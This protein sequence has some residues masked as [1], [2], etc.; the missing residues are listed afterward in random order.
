MKIKDVLQRDPAANPLINQGQARITDRQNERTM[1]ELY[2]E[3]STFV[4]EGQYAEGLQK[5]IRSFV[6]NLGRTN[7]RGAWVSGFFGSGK[8]H[9]LKMLCHL[10]QDTRF[11]D[12]ASARSLVPS[13]PEELNALFRELDI[14]GKRAGGLLAAAGSLPSGTTDKV[15]TTILGI[16]LRATGLPEQYSQARFCLWLHSQGHFEA[17]KSAVEATGKLFDRELNNLYVSGPVARAVMECDP[18]FANGEA[19]AKQLIKAQFPPQTS[20]ITTP[21]FL[22]TA[23][24]CACARLSQ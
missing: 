4:C 6:D 10:W 23:Q 8:S 5:I 7:Q 3:L 18:K 11:P 15:R 14:A 20:D 21:D 24:R 16:L 19:E 2:G 22:R 12:G 13:I 1:Q 17:V 9:L